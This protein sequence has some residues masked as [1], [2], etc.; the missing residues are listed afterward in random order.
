MTPVSNHAPT[1]APRRKL[2][3]GRRGLRAQRLK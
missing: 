1:L 2:R 3:Y